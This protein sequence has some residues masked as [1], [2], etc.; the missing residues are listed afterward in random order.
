MTLLDRTQAP[1]FRL[2]SDY[3]LA[4]PEIFKL[5]SEVDLYAFRELNQE[6]VKLE[7]IFEAGKWYEPKLG[8]SHFTSQMLSKGT[9]K[10]SSF[11]IAEA[12]DMLGGHLEINQ[13]YD[14]VT[15][16]VFSLRKNIL[17]TLDIVVDLLNNPSFDEEE[18]RL[19]KE[20]FL[21]G[22]RVNN[23]KTSVVASKD[24]RREIFGK[25]HPYGSSA[26]EADVKKIERKDLKIFFQDRYSLH[27]GFLIGKLNDDEIKAL[28]SSISTLLSKKVRSKFQR[29]QG[30]SQPSVKPV[31]VQASIRLGKKCLSKSES[32]E[33]FD[34]VMFNHILGGFFG[35][36]LMKNIR[37]EKGLTY[38]I[39]SS[40]NHFLRDSFWVIGAEVNKE[41]AARAIEE[42]KHEIITLQQNLVSEQELE[43]AKNYFIGSWQSENST[44]FSVADKVKSSQLTGVSENYYRSL[45]EHIQ[46]ITPAQ[47]QSAASHFDTVGMIEVQVG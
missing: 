20:I 16:S 4:R 31:S 2:S 3:S 25:D 28:T 36:R 42:I 6:V 39:Y 13:S 41:N 14:L 32:K 40:L 37:E 7:L 8:V 11:Q 29:L 33:Y 17:A 9:D 46:K 35:S 34:A 18:L 38:G 44:L 24:I 22:L 5:N 12:I 1:P 15:V 23:E 27:S 30:S 45:M 43:I 19:M 47:V 10:R 26:E 21:Q